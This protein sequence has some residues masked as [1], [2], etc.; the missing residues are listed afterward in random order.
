MKLIDLNAQYAALKKEIDAAVA[1][2]LESCRFVEGDEIA[3]LEAALAHYIGRGHCM[4]CGSGT[5]ALQLA[6]M[7]YGV[8][9]GDAVF[10]PDVTFVA[11]VEP[12][13]LLGAAPVFCDVTADTRCLSPEGLERQVK[14]VLAEGRLRPRVVVAVHLLGNPADM[15]AISAVCKKYGLVLIE[16]S[17]QGTGASYKGKMCGSFG[18]ISVTSFFPSKPL[19]CYGDGGAIFTDDAGTASLVRSLGRHGSGLGGKYDNVRIGINSRL[20]SVQAAVLLVKLRALCEYELDA[21][22]DV[23]SWYDEALHG[24]FA[25]PVV[26]E[27]CVSNYAQYALLAKDAN[28]RDLAADRLKAAGIPSAV[29]YPTPL[30]RLPVFAGLPVYGEA[31]DNSRHYCE[32]TLSLP[33]HPYLDRQAALRVCDVLM[34]V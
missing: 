25:V 4:S 29:Y 32:R 20:D 15:N 18:D 28:E 7:V 2:V 19:G 31:F 1:G 33:M 10:C 3:R 22:R 17:A 24:R 34:N 26:R 9:P 13:C 21:R 23:A 30:H 5:D 6:Y 12:A 8:G 16:D 14:A 27:G 11:S